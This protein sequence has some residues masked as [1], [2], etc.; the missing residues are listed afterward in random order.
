[1]DDMRSLI[2]RLEELINNV[3]QYVGARYVPRFID[4]PWNDT[5]KYEAL[6][7]V[8]NGSGTSY[9][10]KKPVPVGTPLSDRNYWFVYGS[11]SGAIIN[12]QNQIDAIRRG[13]VMPE[14]FGATGDGITD[15]TVPLKNALTSGYNVILGTDKEYLI[16]DKIEITKGIN[17]IGNNSK[18]FAAVE[19]DLLIIH[20][21]VDHFGLNGVKFEAPPTVNTETAL[22]A[23]I[24]DA[25]DTPRL[26]GA[27]NIIVE[28]CEFK[29]GTIELELNSV[30]DAI[31]NNCIFKNC[32]PKPGETAGGYCILIQS[33]YNV[34]ITNCS[35]TEQK[36]VRH[37][38]YVSV[39]SYHVTNI[40]NSNIKVDN[41][42]FDDSEQQY[43]ASNTSALNIR[44]T[45]GAVISNNYFYHCV[46]FSATSENGEIDIDIIDN[47]FDAQQY[48]TSGDAPNECRY[49][50]NMT[51]SG[52][53]NMI[54]YNIE[55]NKDIN[56]THNNES[57]M[58]IPQYSKGKIVNNFT[59]GNKWITLNGH[60]DVN[61][62]GGEL[63]DYVYRIFENYYTGHVGRDYI[64]K[65]NRKYILDIGGSVINCM[66]LAQFPSEWFAFHINYDSNLSYCYME[67]PYTQTKNSSNNY[68]LKFAWCVDTDAFLIGG[69][70]NG[71]S[72]LVKVSAGNDNTGLAINLKMVDFAGNDYTGTNR[73][74]FKII[75]SRY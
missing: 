31:V 55:N 6:D 38:I 11:T 37:K 75:P 18:I 20:D 12:L 50:I 35:F 41:C 22:V 2:T 23:F 8:D 52:T 44:S 32:N 3:H 29:G 13:F 51:N 27:T 64:A 57:W 70:D 73:T 28:N 5:T 24:E 65:P 1:M 39:N 26:M 9:I 54:S 40:S 62:N 49:N 68:T 48:R 71:S 66:H 67:P 21:S 17:I 63:C 25:N 45:Y 16:S 4:D 34:A 69:S 61:S 15:D 59:D 47:I 74:P 14:M 60:A 58:N 56:S 36:T 30:T 42:Y 10:A 33:S 46:G 19:T 7:V 53:T 43:A 72:Q